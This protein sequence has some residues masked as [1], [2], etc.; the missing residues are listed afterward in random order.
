M[1]EDRYYQIEAEESVFKYLEKFPDG[2][3]LVA[4]PT[5]SGKTVVMLRIVKRLLDDDCKV[6]ILTDERE[7][8]R[9][10]YLAV[11]HL[12]KTG[13][14]SAGLESKTV[15]NLTVAGIHSCYS[16]PDLFKRFDKVIIDECHMIPSED[17]SMYRKFIK[18]IGKHNRIG[19]TATPYR[20][21]QGYIAGEGKIFDKIV[22]DYT[23]GSKF[24]KL[25]NQGF[26][27]NLVTK[28][29]K[30]KLNLEGVKTI[31]GD[32]SIKD[33]ASKFDRDS[34]TRSAVSELIEKGSDRK[35]WLIFAI[36]IDHA[37]HICDLLNENKIYSM[38]VHSKMEF[39]RTMIMNMYK[40]DQLRAIVSV[41]ML[42]KG[43][44]IPS[45]DL[46]GLLRPTQSLNLHVQMPG[47][48]LRVS[49]GKDNCLV[50]DFAGNTERL[51]AINLAKPRVK[52]KSGVG[53]PITKTCPDCETI[54][55]PMRKICLECGHVFLFTQ[56]LRPVQF[57]DEII[58]D[59]SKWHNV[60]N[61][62]YSVHKKVGSVETIKVS[63][64]IGLVVVNEWLCPN[65]KGYAKE[66]AIK[67]LAK[68]G[69]EYTDLPSALLSLRA[70]KG[71][72]RVRVDRSSKYPIITGYE[73]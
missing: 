69:I 28:D 63:Y 51:G 30:T 1:F 2:H 52:K 36:D 56:K 49:E 48:G 12:C 60:S 59:I 39:D 71:A 40:S 19:L 32:F 20:T 34:I 72:K 35:K 68:R 73:L 67:W 6:L 42:T 70:S 26:I 23:F 10:N 11:K 53:E 25:V 54:T 33:M 8:I 22:S 62:T 5:G 4:Q 3:P 9:Q 45:I 15:E 29:P 44:N 43:L 21:G 24:T 65:H 47:R 57:G 41:G 61:I 14:F 50:L 16:V 13:L 37:D 55:S 31:G 64:L 38:V 66:V 58:S 18:G 27:S 17:S 46:I 7:V